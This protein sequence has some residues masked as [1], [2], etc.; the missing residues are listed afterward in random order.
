VE[1]PGNI[2]IASLL[3]GRGHH[4]RPDEALGEILDRR[5]LALAL[6]SYLFA[7]PAGR[8]LQTARL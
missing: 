1:Q 7:G 4:L 3:E 2:A 8:A 6:V 5:D